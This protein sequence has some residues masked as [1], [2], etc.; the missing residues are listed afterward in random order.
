MQQW[1]LKTLTAGSF[2]LLFGASIAALAEGQPED[3]IKYR[4]NVM[5]ANGAHMSA[6]SAILQGKVDYKKQLA[7]H[8]KAV[9]NINKDIPSLFP[10]G[11]NTGNT[12]ALPAI[13]DNRAEFEKRANDAKQKSAAFAKAA[14][15]ADAQAKFK[16]LSETCKSCHKDFRKEE[17]EHKEEKEK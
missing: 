13:W 5:K 12:K 4:Q 17:H 3:T 10:N 8:A 2:F 9:E 11:T 15:T 1:V 6:I 16:E 14:M 7:D